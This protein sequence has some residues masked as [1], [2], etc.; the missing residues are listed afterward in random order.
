VPPVS[1]P[2][3]FRLHRVFFLLSTSSRNLWTNVKL[4]VHSI[5]ERTVTA[6][7]SLLPGMRG[8]SS[9]LFNVLM[10]VYNGHCLFIRRESISSFYHLT[11]GLNINCEN[12]ITDRRFSLCSISTSIVRDYS[13][14]LVVPFKRACRTRLIAQVEPLT[15]LPTS[16]FR[17]TSF[18]PWK[19]SAWI[20]R[21]EIGTRERL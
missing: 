3:S 7:S 13:L 14:C 20:N 12:I 6:F 11:I 18:V 16:P 8:K 4:I 17:A 10:H 19:L 15:L 21:N 5:R 1:S 2:S 9:L